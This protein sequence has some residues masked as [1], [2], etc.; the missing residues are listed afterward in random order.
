[1]ADFKKAALFVR[2]LGL[3]GAATRARTQGDANPA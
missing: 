1:M 2:L 3:E